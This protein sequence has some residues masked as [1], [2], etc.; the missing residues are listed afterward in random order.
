MTASS[1]P[2]THAKEAGPTDTDGFVFVSR[3]VH[4]KVDGEDFHLD[5]VFYHICQRSRRWVPLDR[6]PAAHSSPAEADYGKGVAARRR[7]CSPLPRRL[8][9]WVSSVPQVAEAIC[10]APA[11]PAPSFSLTSRSQ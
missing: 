3:Q 7:G 1:G 9:I 5:W 10:K 6:Y 8:P 4:F 2:A 11:R